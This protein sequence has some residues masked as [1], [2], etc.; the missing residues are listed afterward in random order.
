MEMHCFL[1]FLQIYANNIKKKYFQSLQ[2]NMQTYGYSANS[3]NCSVVF[4]E[5]C[6]LH[7][8]EFILHNQNIILQYVLFPRSTILTSTLT[9]F[10]VQETYFFYCPS[11]KNRPEVRP[12]YMCINIEIQIFPWH[13]H[14]FKRYI[15]I[16]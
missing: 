12:T 11:Y 1:Q 16:S 6:L 5:S 9:L 10:L 7:L 15:E 14:L 2:N 3:V 8:V 4:I 13:S